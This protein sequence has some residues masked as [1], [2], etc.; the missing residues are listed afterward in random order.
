MVYLRGGTLSAAK[1]GTENFW[2]VTPDADPKRGVEGLGKRPS[3]IIVPV[4]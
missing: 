3:E 4:L 1:K 2:G